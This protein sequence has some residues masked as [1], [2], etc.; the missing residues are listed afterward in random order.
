MD[1]DINR[2]NR[3][4]E[5]ALTF[6]AWLI[7]Y[8]YQ[9]LYREAVQRADRALQYH[10]QRLYNHYREQWDLAHRQPEEKRQ[11]TAAPDESN[12]DP[13]TDAQEQA[14]QE[15][16]QMDGSSNIDQWKW[17]HDICRVRAKRGRLSPPILNYSTWRW[18]SLTNFATSPCAHALSQTWSGA[19]AHTDLPMYA[20]DLSTFPCGNITLPT[21]LQALQRWNVPF[22]RMRAKKTVAGP[23][24]LTYTWERTQGFKNDPTGAITRFR[25]NI[26][27]ISNPIAED[28]WSPWVNKYEHQSS[29]IRIIMNGANAAPSR[30]HVKIVRFLDDDFA[31]RRF[32][33]DKD[34]NLTQWDDTVADGEKC[35]QIGGFWDQFWAKRESNPLR[36]T[37]NE[38]ATPLYN[39]VYHKTFEFPP[40]STTDQDSN[41]DQKIFKLYFKA[42]N[43]H[44]TST[45]IVDALQDNVVWKDGN[46]GF[47]YKVDVGTAIPNESNIFPKNQYCYYLLIYAD[48]FPKFTNDTNTN[49]CPSFDLMVRGNYVTPINDL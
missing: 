39:V 47:G 11:R 15:Y 23:D 34:D 41:P 48:T 45:G 6:G 10:Y 36:T 18:Q 43:C 44:N 30:V 46:A 16:Q 1:I 40:S 17:I 37:K 3:A 26:E 22:Y 24:D 13:P 21:G 27:K 29:D 8:G 49:L 5:F 38:V 2:R 32:Y 33:I 19:N 12:Q 7:R 14:T 4:R 31:P 25:S 9:R 35:R 42:G 28:P 20:F